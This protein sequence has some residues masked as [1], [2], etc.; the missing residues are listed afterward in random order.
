M[1]KAADKLDKGNKS[2][3]TQ[4]SMTMVKQK[5]IRSEMVM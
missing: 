3:K 1:D 5:Q 2:L 4:M